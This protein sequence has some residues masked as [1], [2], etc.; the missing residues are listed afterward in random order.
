[1]IYA[2]PVY[3]VINII[4]MSST[5]TSNS[6]KQPV[7]DFSSS[8]QLDCYLEIDGD[9]SAFWVDQKCNGQRIKQCLEQVFRLEPATVKL[10]VNGLELKDDMPVVQQGLAR[11]G[12][13]VVTL[14]NPMVHHVL[15]ML[16]GPPSVP[17]EKVYRSKECIVCLEPLAH[18][19]VIELIIYMPCGHANVCTSCY[20]KSIEVQPDIQHNS[21]AICSICKK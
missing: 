17:V 7:R 10:T 12:T 13:I 14:I 18:K 6:S 21:L 16:N 19:P 2:S 4:R 15:R 8:D 3:N 11:N 5:Q 1:M 9:K 20:K